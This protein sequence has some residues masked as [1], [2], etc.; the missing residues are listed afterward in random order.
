LIERKSATAAAEQST[1][2]RDDLC[3]SVFSTLDHQSHS[4]TA[5]F[6]EAAISDFKRQAQSEPRDE[7]ELAR[8]Q[9]EVTTNRELLNSFR[10]QLVASDVTQA[11]ETTNL[12]LRIEILDPPQLP[13]APSSPN[14]MM[15]LIAALALGPILGIGVALASE[16]MDTTLRSLAD[17]E[18]VFR[19][20]VL[21]TTPLLS[22]V[23]AQQVRIRRYWVPATVT[24]IVLVTAA[25]L[26]TRENLLRDFVAVGQ[27]VRA[28][29]PKDS[30]TP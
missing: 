25:F 23:P 8:L 13:L 7:M 1:Q 10:A 9:S 18:R 26:L 29:D 22:R 6:L 11:A 27:T 20:P 14:R 30:V 12:G 15:I 21:G 19:G 24:V 4:Q 3:R 2:V 5:G 17:F 16:I 28:I